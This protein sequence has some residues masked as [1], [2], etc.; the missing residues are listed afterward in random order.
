[1]KCNRVI[2]VSSLLAACR[3]CSSS[4]YALDECEVRRGV[5]ACRTADS[6]P[7]CSDGSNRPDPGDHTLHSR[8]GWT[9]QNF[10]LRGDYRS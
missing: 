10:L 8:E 2:F 9:V 4:N 5:R 3:S 6:C 7:S 1:M